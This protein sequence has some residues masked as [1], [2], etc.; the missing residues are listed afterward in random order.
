M[1]SPAGPSQTSQSLPSGAVSADVPRKA[2]GRA[3]FWGRSTYRLLS[4][5]LCANV[6][7]VFSYRSSMYMPHKLLHELH[8]CFKVK[9]LVGVKLPPTDFGRICSLPKALA[10]FSWPQ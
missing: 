5:N 3:G 10:G 9:G 6:S 1:V 2:S 4:A 8:T 7:Q